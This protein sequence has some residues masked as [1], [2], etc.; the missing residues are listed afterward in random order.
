MKWIGFPWPA[1]AYLA[2]IAAVGAF[3]ARGTWAREPLMVRR[4]HVLTVALAIGLLGGAGIL[5]GQAALNGLNT[6]R[7]VRL[8][9][10]ESSLRREAI[11]AAEVKRIARRQA[12]LER[13]TQR[14]LARRLLSAL[15]LIRRSPALR[16]RARRI[17]PELV[18]AGLATGPIPTPSR[19]RTTPRR[20]RTPTRPTPRPPTATS[21]A[22]AP[23]PAPSP[24]TTTPPAPPDVGVDLPCI[25]VGVL[26]V[27]C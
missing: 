27:G 26:T 15:K 14:E 13:P 22:P 19:P 23:P 4:G 6:E 17:A 9:Q 20:P 3:V 8:R 24:P 5:L 12:R 10:A 21:P 1:V 7:D 18:A 25:D 11:S 16:A 2:I